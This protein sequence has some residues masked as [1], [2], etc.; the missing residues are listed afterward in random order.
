MTYKCFNCN[1]TFSSQSN[2]NKHVKVSKRCKE[3][4]GEDVSYHCVYCKFSTVDKSAFEAH[5]KTYK[6]RGLN[7][8]VPDYSKVVK[9]LKELNTIKRQVK[10][11]NS[12]IKNLEAKKLT[13]KWDY[14][15]IQNK[16]C[17]SERLENSYERRLEYKKE[18]IELKQKMS[19]ANS[20]IFAFFQ[21]P[22]QHYI[23]TWK[24]NI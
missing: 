23:Q 8:K 4:K 10:Y 20:W 3:R 24:N 16:P 6:C 7:L 17:D 14:I 9:M 21:R 2:L 18:I 12:S 11:V 22:I 15:K 5:K 13:D 19:K 1:K